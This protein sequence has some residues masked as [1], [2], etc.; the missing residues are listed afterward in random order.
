MYNLKLPIP[1]GFVIT[2]ES[3][4]DY[5][6]TLEITESLERQ[7]TDALSEVTK[8]TGKAFGTYEKT[9]VPLLLS[10]RSGAAISM[11]GMMDTVL[12][13]GM[14]QQVADRLCV[15]SNNPR[16]VY[17]TYRRFIQMFGNVVLGV[18]KNKYEDLLE[19]AKQKAGVEHDYQLTP[20][21]LQKLI[22]DYL[23]VAPIPTDP[24]EQVRMTVEAIFNRFV[25]YILDM[26]YILLH[27]DI[28]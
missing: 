13:V 15:I 12:N 24:V 22:S 28:S 23:H 10:I 9:S 7:Y 17:D 4:I 26:T 8:M 3:C 21:F 1:Y 5:F 25:N 14:N 19:A 11:P 16:W 27:N 6:Q 2:T 18:S 20:A